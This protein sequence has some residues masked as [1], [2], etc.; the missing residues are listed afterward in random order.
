MKQTQAARYLEHRALEHLRKAR[1]LFVLA[2]IKRGARYDCL[3]RVFRLNARKVA[4]LKLG[5]V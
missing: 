5:T 4:H 2:G 1:R 3:S